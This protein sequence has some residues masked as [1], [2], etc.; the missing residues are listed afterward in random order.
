MSFTRVK[1]I[2]SIGFYTQIEIYIF[3]RTPRSQI[4]GFL[5]WSFNF[6]SQ[7]IEKYRMRYIYEAAPWP[8]CCKPCWKEVTDE[9]WTTPCWYMLMSPESFTPTCAPCWYI[10]LVV[11]HNTQRTNVAISLR[12]VLKRLN[13]HAYSCFSLHLYLRAPGCC[14]HL[15][16]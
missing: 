11:L 5:Y 10:C 16:S 12:Y 4:S 8:R 13:C 6:P 2:K 14:Q 9:G 15:L 7:I 3:H 1:D